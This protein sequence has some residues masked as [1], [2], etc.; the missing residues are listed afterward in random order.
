MV[1]GNH[2]SQN[3]TFAKQEAMTE[4]HN[5][6]VDPDGWN[7]FLDWVEGKYLQ[8]LESDPMCGEKC[9]P[10][11]VTIRREYHGKTAVAPVH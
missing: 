7:K 1:I 2:P 4:E 9:D 11:T 6:F 8:V 5:P 10:Q 3:Q